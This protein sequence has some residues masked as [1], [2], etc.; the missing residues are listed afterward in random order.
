MIGAI[1]CSTTRTLGATVPSAIGES[2]RNTN[3]TFV[4]TD[5]TE[6]TACGC[7]IL[8]SMIIF[9]IIRRLTVWFVNVLLYFV[10][11]IK[12]KVK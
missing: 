2:I 12:I 10:L 11:I 8:K 6:C 7:T 5:E 4:T 1:R 3:P 9:S